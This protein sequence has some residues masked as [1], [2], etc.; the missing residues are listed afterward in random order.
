MEES[1]GVQS[2]QAKKGEG[3]SFTAEQMSTVRQE[4]RSGTDE[5]DDPAVAVSELSGEGLGGNVRGSGFFHG[6]RR[7]TLSTEAGVK[8]VAKRTKSTQ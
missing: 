4:G 6:K 3:S 5:D 8:V 7:R 2:E 1:S